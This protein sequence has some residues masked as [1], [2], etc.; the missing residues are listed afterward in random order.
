MASRIRALKESA[1]TADTLYFDSGDCIRAGNLG[2]PLKP[3]EAWALLDQAGCDASVLGNRETHL[4]PSAFK[5]K[6]EGHRHPI[7]VANLRAKDGS[8]PLAANL[9]LVHAGLRVGVFGIMVPMVTERT[10]AKA[11]SAYLW[12][13]PLAE[14]QKQAKALR[15]DVDCLIALTHIGFKQDQALAELCPD[16]DIILGGHSHTVLEQPVRVG[17]TFVCQGGSHG[18][19]IGIY[20]WRRRGDM[21]GGLQGIES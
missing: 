18:R 8:R 15:A 14:A 7:L 19:F 4:L 2:V 16:I 13:P 6:L 11:A 21:S 10:A 1:G 3:E 5:A 9:I 12:D 20:D 17:R